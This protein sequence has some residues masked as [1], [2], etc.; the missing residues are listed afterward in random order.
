MVFL[1]AC[2]SKKVAMKQDSIRTVQKFRVGMVELSSNAFDASIFYDCMKNY[3]SAGIALDGQTR[4]EL[5]A[6]GWFSDNMIASLQKQDF[7]TYG[8]IKNFSLLMM[9][10]KNK[11]QKN[12]IRLVNFLSKQVITLSLEPEQFACENVLAAAKLMVIDSVPPYADVYINNRQIGEAPVWTSLNSGT[13]ELQCKL[14]DDSFPKTTLKVPGNVKYLCKRQNQTMQGIENSN[15]ENSDGSE[16][17]QSW[18]LYGLVG[19]LSL[20]SA[21]LPFLLFL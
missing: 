14:P 1:F 8:N 7:E 19:L 18:F 10:F 13:Y 12:F 11:E 3:P 17:T 9:L 16:K 2:A 21:V 5:E 20:G 6:T 15:D 4:Q